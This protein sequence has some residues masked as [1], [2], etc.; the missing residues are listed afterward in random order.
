MKRCVPLALLAL[1]GC[2]GLPVIGIET[3]YSVT[4]DKASVATGGSV[5]L[6]AEVVEGGHTDLEVSV[7]EG[8]RGGTVVKTASGENT[9]PDG[10]TYTAPANP[11]TYHV[12]VK[13]LNGTKVEATKTATMV[14]VV[15]P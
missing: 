7:R 12:V 5:D 15:P 14:V 2:G 10:A 1:A 11:G 13:F 6:R 3:I 4:P 8:A 9:I